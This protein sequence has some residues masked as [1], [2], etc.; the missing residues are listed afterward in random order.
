V[1]TLVQTPRKPLVSYFLYYLNM[2]SYPRASILQQTGR[3]VAS[4][5]CSVILGGVFGV[6]ALVGLGIPITS[7][8]LFMAFVAFVFGAIAGFLCS[9]ALILGLWHGH[10]LVGVLWIAIPTAVAAFISGWLT[11]S[12]DNLLAIMLISM[13]VYVI[14]SLLRGLIC[15]MRYKRLRLPQCNLCGYETTGLAPRAVCPECGAATT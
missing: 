5:V 2:S 11:R 1:R 8:M 10:W 7:D 12:T 13:T 14:V 3:G 9:P 4:C 6:I 15:L